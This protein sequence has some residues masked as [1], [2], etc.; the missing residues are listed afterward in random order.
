MVLPTEEKPEAITESTTERQLRRCLEGVRFP[1]SKDDLLVAALS[2]RCD[3]Q[4]ADSLRTIPS[5]TYAN[6]SQVLAQTSVRIT[7]C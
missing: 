1:A 4:A 2:D 7:Q 3:E 6:A 5:I